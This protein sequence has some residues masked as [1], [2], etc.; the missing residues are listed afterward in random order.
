VNG[1]STLEGEIA[2]GGVCV[3]KSVSVAS[4]PIDDGGANIGERG[5][6]LGKPY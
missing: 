4:I 3:R 5:G 2:A 1:T 6:Y